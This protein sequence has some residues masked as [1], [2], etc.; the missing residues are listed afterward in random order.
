M[1][2]DA[3]SDQRDPVPVAVEADTVA[4]LSQPVTTARLALLGSFATLSIVVGALLGGLTFETHVSGSW[5]FGMPGGP[6]G[7]IG[8]NANQAPTYALIAVYGGLILLCRA[9]WLLLRQ[10]QN[11]VGLPVRKVVLVVAIWAIPLLVAP[12]LF[13]RDV[14]SY[15]GQGQL[16]TQ[17]IDP[18]RHGPGVLGSTPFATLPDIV[19][20]HTPAPYGPTFLG[21]DAVLDEA[22][23]HRILPDI[24]LLRLLEIAGLAL[25]AAATPTLARSLKRDP[26]EAILLGVGSPLALITLVGG[27]HNDALMLGLLMAGLAVARRF[28]AVPGIVLCALGGGVKSPALLGILFI[29][30]TWSGIDAHIKRRLA[31]TAVAGLIGLA[32]LEAVTLL[33]GLSWGWLRTTSSV[34]QSFTGVTP[35]SALSRLVSD[36]GRVVHLHI[37]VYDAH[38]VFSTV[39]LVLAGL[40]GIR[41]LLNSPRHGMVRALGLTLLAVALLGP[42]VWAWYVTWGIVVLA[43]VAAGWLRRFCIALI[44]YWTLIG[45]TKVKNLYL[46]VIHTAVLPDIVVVVALLAAAVVPLGMFH[47]R[48][49]PRIDPSSPASDPTGLAA[50]NA[51]A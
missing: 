2:R 14:Y 19:W 40:L 37:S 11:H 31:D 18:Y 10:T 49:E 3:R 17:H 24:V 47:H 15:A 44:V 29:G 36:L 22:S 33:T 41:L 35:V 16:V 20:R 50:P 51:S 39:G 32:T 43:P 38:D 30:W 34:N 21:L 1:T 7:S 45:A 4:P 8:S 42:V 5:F 48:T 26:A 27:A 13:S 28:G 6:L 23:G 12:P 25:A 46:T 9:W